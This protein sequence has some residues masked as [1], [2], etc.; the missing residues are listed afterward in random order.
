MGDPSRRRAHVDL[1]DITLLPA[2]VEARQH[3][4][5]D[6]TGDPVDQMLTDDDTTLLDHPTV[7]DGPNENLN[8]KIK[9]AAADVW[10]VQAQS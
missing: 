4:G 10:S 5:F 8:V 7:S 2:L 3:L 6:P 1:G 9:A